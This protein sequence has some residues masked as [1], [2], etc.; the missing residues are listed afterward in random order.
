MTVKD[1]KKKFKKARNSSNPDEALYEFFVQLFR[2]NREILPQFFRY[3]FKKYSKNT[4]SP[5][6][7]R[8]KEIIIRL[9]V[10]PEFSHLLID[11]MGLFGKKKN[12]NH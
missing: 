8:T 4:E 3:V 6:K 7:I 10:Q 5:R 1:A 9:L 2:E 12:K 11:Q